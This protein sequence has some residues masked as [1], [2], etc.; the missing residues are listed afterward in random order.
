MADYALLREAA[1][2]GSIDVTQPASGQVKQLLAAAK[3][4]RTPQPELLWSAQAICLHWDVANLV[5]VFDPELIILA[6]EQMQFDHLYAEEGP[7]RDAQIHR[8]DRQVPARG[9]D[10]QMGQRD[11]GP[12]GRRPMRWILFM[13]WPQRIVREDVGLSFLRLFWSP[14]LQWPMCVLILLMSLRMPYTGGWEHFVGGGL[15][16][17]DCDGD[18]RVDVFAAGG[19]SAPALWRNTSV[20]GTIS[21]APLPRPCASPIQLALIR[22]ISPMTACWTV[23]V[24]RV[25]PDVLLQGDGACGFAPTTLPELTFEDQWSTAFSAI[26]EGGQC[27]ANH[28]VRGTMLTALILT[29]RFEACDTN[30]LMRPDGTATRACRWPPG[31][32][33]LS[34]LMSDWSP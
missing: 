16:V 6:G 3:A 32:C 31:F 13:R 20:T 34:M 24:L 22:W 7:C 25:G 23:V 1:S 14:P 30:A 10:P 18:E 26:W 8:S 9:C 12:R 15:A 29:A 17:F 21:F 11:V 28:G 27:P 33:P 19:A 4:G 5:N 2:V